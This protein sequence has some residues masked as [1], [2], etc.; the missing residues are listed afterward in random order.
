ME[1][2]AGAGLRVV[3]AIRSLLEEWTDGRYS[4]V[5][6]RLTRVLSG[7]DCFG[8][9]RIAG[10]EA[11]EQC[12]HC[13]GVTGTWR[14]L[15][16]C[17]AW[18]DQRRVLVQTVGED[19]SLP[20]IVE[21]MVGSEKCWVEDV[22]SQKEAAERENDPKAF[23]LR[24]KGTGRGG[25]ASSNVDSPRGIFDYFTRPFGGALG[26]SFIAQGYLGGGWHR[27]VYSRRRPN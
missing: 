19:L 25:A 3:G 10:R 12:H 7:H 1:Y 23:P 16:K 15:E 13:E 22:F 4:P 17:P 18:A 26:K 14:T 21:K 11:D 5:T 6:Y 9:S 8:S 27:I 20:A 24:R 2:E